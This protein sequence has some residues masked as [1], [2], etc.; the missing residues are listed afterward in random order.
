MRL[1]AEPALNGYQ[2]IFLLKWAGGAGRIDEPEIQPAVKGERS[3]TII[4]K[5]M[6]RKNNIRPQDYFN[7]FENENLKT[8]AIRGGGMMFLVGGLSV[9]FQIGG[10]IVLGRLL[11]P[12]DFGLVVMAS[13]ITNLFFVFQDI[14]RHLHACF[15]PVTS[16][17]LFGL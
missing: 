15:L 17:L 14:Y 16:R 2:A 13:V 7:H 9:V 5:S 6:S 10:V 3:R 8:L 4:E 12:E 11:S 1:E